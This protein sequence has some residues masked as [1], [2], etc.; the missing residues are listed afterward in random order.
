MFHERQDHQ[1]QIFLV[2]RDADQPQYVWVIKFTHA[3]RLLQE[4]PG[5]VSTGV[6]VLW[7]KTK[8]YVSHYHQI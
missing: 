6:R 5:I 3:Q 8:I 4:P 2:Q 1:G 7:N